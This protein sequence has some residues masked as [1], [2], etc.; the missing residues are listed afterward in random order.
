MPISLEWCCQKKN[1]VYTEPVQVSQ[2]KPLTQKEF[3]EMF[4]G[5][6]LSCGICKKAFSL[7]QHEVVAYCGGC[8]KF[9]HCGIAGKCVGPNCSFTIKGEQ[10]RQTWC[11]NCIPKNFIINL[12]KIGSP[13]CDCLCMECADDP[14]TNHKFKLMI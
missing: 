2:E 12:Q 14:N 3:T 8:Y 6:V 9:L 4:F 1:K 13:E 5:E 11:Q 10:Y 7:R